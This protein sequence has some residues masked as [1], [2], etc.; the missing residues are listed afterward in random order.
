M[1][2]KKY[3]SLF[4]AV[5]MMFS[6]PVISFAN[7]YDGHW[8]YSDIEYLI[9]KNIVIPNDGLVRPDEFI[10]RAEFVK[11][12]NNI[13]E[14]PQINTDNIYLDLSEDKWYYS[15]IL[16]AT[17]YGILSGDGTGYCYP[18]NK[19]TRAEASVILSR[20]LKLDIKPCETAFSDNSETEI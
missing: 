9:N 2:F 7:D 18:E 5:C 3:L 13:F 17:G 16:K 15:E 20:V 19:I 1:K 6:L 10:T 12:I 4:I 11:V 8:A 14:I